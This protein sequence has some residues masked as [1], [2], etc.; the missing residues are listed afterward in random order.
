MH[1]FSMLQTFMLIVDG[2]YLLS[3]IGIVIVGFSVANR[4]NRDTHLVTRVAL[5]SPLF[6]AVLGLIEMLSNSHL[7]G[8]PAII[9]SMPLLFLYSVLALEMRGVVVVREFCARHPSAIIRERRQLR[10]K[11]KEASVCQ[12]SSI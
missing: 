10:Q 2:M 9:V 8:W 3:L 11:L 5:L 7:I 12:T 1:S 6:A 4:L